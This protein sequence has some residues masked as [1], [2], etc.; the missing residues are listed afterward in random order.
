MIEHYFLIDQVKAMNKHFST[1]ILKVTLDL[2][3]IVS[4]KEFLINIDFFLFYIPS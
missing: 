1:K 2:S 3:V 4:L